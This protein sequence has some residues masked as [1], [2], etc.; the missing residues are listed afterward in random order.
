MIN[1]KI[2]WNLCVQW[3]YGTTTWERLSYLKESYPVEVAEYYFVQGIDNKPMFVC[4]VPYTLNK[5]KHIIV[6]VS[7][8]YNRCEYKYGF[9]IPRTVE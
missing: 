1:I 4:W 8:Q 7:K 9:L 3:K 6:A 5:R 2:G